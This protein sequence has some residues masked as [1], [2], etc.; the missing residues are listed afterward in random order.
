[1]GRPGGFLTA[2]CAWLAALCLLQPAFAN[3][4]APL[5][6]DPALE[7]RMTR[8]TAELRC[9]VCQNQTIADSNADLAVDLRRQVR[10]ML[11]KGDDD[12]QI[13]R[14]MTDRYGDFVLY[15]P[16]VKATTVL[17]W[18]GPALMLLFG[19]GAL[20]LVMRRRARTGAEQFES[21]DPALFADPHQS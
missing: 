12:A 3:D 4:A 15:R 18:F 14:Y 10:E 13:I 11:R 2:L 1:L 21:D 19:F 5:A 9:L 20:A 6:A 8:I 17:L 16:P 7:A